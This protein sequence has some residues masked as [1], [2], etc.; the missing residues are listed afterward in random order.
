[1][2]YNNNPYPP[3]TL[4]NLPYDKV[5]NTVKLYNPLF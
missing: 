1:M 2:I 3:E 5:A 4:Y